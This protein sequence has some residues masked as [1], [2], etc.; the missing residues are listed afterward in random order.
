MLY[1]PFFVYNFILFIVESNCF[2]EF[3]SKQILCRGSSCFWN[4]SV[5]QRWSLIAERT[6]HRNILRSSRVWIID[7]FVIYFI[8][9]S[10]E[11]K[12]AFNQTESKKKKYS[13]FILHLPNPYPIRRLTLKGIGKFYASLG[14]E[15]E[16]SRHW[17][18]VKNPYCIYFITNWLHGDIIT[19][20]Y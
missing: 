2:S 14:V 1:I 9:V 11:N 6:S 16:I 4:P 12:L 19:S 3:P 13:S 10:I 17:N 8:L 7:Y 15:C 20:T 18:I 5:S